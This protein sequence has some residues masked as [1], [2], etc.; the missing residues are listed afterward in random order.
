MRSSQRDVLGSD[1]QGLIGCGKETQY[2]SIYNG[3]PLGSYKQGSDIIH[4]FPL[5]EEQTE[6]AES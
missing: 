6:C 5:K 4:V 2:Y 1:C 3:I